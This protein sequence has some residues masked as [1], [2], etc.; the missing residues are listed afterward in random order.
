MLLADKKPEDSILMYNADKLNAMGAN[1]SNFGRESIDFQYSESVVPSRQNLQG[2]GGHEDMVDQ[3]PSSIDFKL[4]T[5]ENQSSTSKSMKLRSPSQQTETL[6]QAEES[7]RSS[8]L[9]KDISEFYEKPN[10]DMASLRITKQAPNE[11]LKVI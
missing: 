5:N 9:N 3:S 10:L 11:D 8:M 7:Q 4:T 1:Q 6:H 2:S